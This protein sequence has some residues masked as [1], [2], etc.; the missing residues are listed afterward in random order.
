M[1]SKAMVLEAPGKM[2]LQE[3]DIP[4]IGPEDALLKVEMV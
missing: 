1:K 3:F 4:E 2:S